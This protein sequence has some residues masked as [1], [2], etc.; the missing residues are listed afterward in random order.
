LTQS[1]PTVRKLILS[2]L[3]KKKKL[4]NYK[5]IQKT[6]CHLLKDVC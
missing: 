2:S 5:R 3:V 4:F 1:G 6:R